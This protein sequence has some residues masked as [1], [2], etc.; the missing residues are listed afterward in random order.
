M[1]I[2]NSGVLL[3]ASE[4]WKITQRTLSGLQA[5]IKQI[6]VE[7]NWQRTSAAAAKQKKTELAWSHIENKQ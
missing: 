4:S 2:F 7:E 1:K 3:Y 6:T 5:C